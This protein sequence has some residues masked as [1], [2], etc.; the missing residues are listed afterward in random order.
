[1]SGLDDLLARSRAP[2]TFVERRE[3]TLSRDK[4]VE[5]LREFSLRHPAGYVLELVQAA[6]FAGATYIAIDVSDSDILVA[7]VGGEACTASQLENIFDYLFLTRAGSDTR[8]LSQLAIGLNALLQR[9]PK[10]VRI[11]SGDG[12]PEGTV[13]VDLDRRGK[14]SVGRPQLAMAGTYLLVQQ[15]SGW[16][17]RFDGEDFHAE[18]ALVESRCVYSPVPI[19]LNGRAPF[20][21]RPSTRL[22]MFGTDDEQIFED[23]SRRGV[24]AI[25]GRSERAGA[26]RQPLGVRIVVGGVW[27]TTMDLP[28]LGRAPGSVPLV[29]VICDDGLRK[30]A[31]QSDIV[32][33]RSFVRMLHAAQPH[34]AT[35]IRRSAGDGWRPPALPELP[36]EAPDGPAAAAGPVPE[37][38]PGE[39]LQLGARADLPLDQLAELPAGA[40]VFWCRPEDAVQLRAAADAARFPF[41]VVLVTP[42]QAR[43]LGDRAPQLALSPL[44]SSADVDFVQNTLERQQELYRL[45]AGFQHRGRELGLRLRLD[46]GGCTDPTRADDDEIPV[47]LGSADRTRWCGAVPLG[48][49]GVSA[50]VISPGEAPD[51]DWLEQVAERVV[52]E[53]WRWLLPGPQQVRVDG[54]GLRDLRCALLRESLRPMFVEH[55]HGLE[56]Q[57]VLLGLDLEQR[58]VIL[59]QPLADAVDGP[60]TLRRLIEAQ[61]TERV[62]LVADPVERARLLPV[63]AL[64]GFG[65]LVLDPADATPVCALGCYAGGWRTVGRRDLSWKGFGHVLYVPAS[66]RTPPLLADWARRTAPQALIAAV[67][68]PGAPTD[69]DWEQGVALLRDTL[70]R[71]DRGGG[72]GELAV[73]EQDAPQRVAMG[74]SALTLLEQLRPERWSQLWA[75][76]PPR[77]WPQRARLLDQ[78]TVVP[79]GGAEPAGLDHL[80]L[81]FD[82]LQA[83]HAVLPEHRLRL[84]LDDAPESYGEDR[85][86]E[87]W[88]VRQQIAGSGLEGWL[89]LRVPY[90]PTSGVLVHSARSLHALHGGEQS[91]PVHGMIRLPPGATVPSEEQEELLMLERLLLYQ[92][93]ARLLDAGLLEGSRLEAARHYAAAFAVDAWRRGRLHRA[94]AQ[95]LAEAVPCPP[96]TSLLAWLMSDH[97]GAAPPSVHPTTA[98]LYAAG[99]VDAA[100]G[101]G[102]AQDLGDRFSRAL[103]IEHDLRVRLDLQ[104]LEDEDERVRLTDRGALDTAT[105]V[106]NLRNP[107]VARAVDG[108]SRGFG[109]EDRPLR[110]SADRSVQRARDLVLLD[111]AWRFV[112]WA[113]K[114]GRHA[115]LA[116]LHRALLAASLEG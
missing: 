55:D 35:L 53:A 6:V 25:P 45:E 21:Y 72:W 85:D 22:R 79:R 83:V 113:R 105:M 76:E 10:L 2:G 95:R 92:S 9:D 56:L 40:Q 4:A 3:F 108:S 42:G 26:K 89:G 54:P 24:L 114:R 58:E 86:A 16:L 37:A 59:D 17:D 111:M 12:T 18:Q 69:V 99:P 5:K 60:L 49:P 28:V 48:L 14:G 8:H 51:G 70:R 7:W 97:P 80:E 23:D 39:L 63:E 33:D 81:S 38:L 109:L 74:R 98:R 30:T 103:G 110:D 87:H 91:L 31:D 94:G 107:I 47:T 75:S 82:E 57:A 68:A 61:G 116:A 29:G 93:L 34:A 78:A 96:H 115:D 104:Y 36:E 73:D 102:G 32:Q 106:L 1:M 13:R 44:A 20:G 52:A 66:F 62:I 46:L 112:R 77:P 71:L 101:F 27:I 100:R 65:H 11:E 50:H 15:R 43:S 88:V 64:L 67:S 84:H 19:L 90:D 41:P